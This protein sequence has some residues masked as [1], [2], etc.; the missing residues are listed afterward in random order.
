MNLNEYQQLARR[1]ASPKDKKDE[2][3]HLF[4]GLSGE[5]GEISEK[6]KKIIRDQGSD[7]TKLDLDDLTKEM[8]DVLWHLA[9][10]ADYFDI[11]FEKVGQA[12]IDKLASRLERGT[13]GGSGDNR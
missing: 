2:L 9:I 11:P 7:F 13:I 5:V 10:L 1:T 6:A 3:F 4:L 8:G 12:N